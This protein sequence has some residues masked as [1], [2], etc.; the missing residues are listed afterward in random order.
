MSDVDKIFAKWT[1]RASKDTL[2]GKELSAKWYAEQV[3]KEIK[4]IIDNK[5]E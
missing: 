4:E 2:E 3:E 5:E 1:A